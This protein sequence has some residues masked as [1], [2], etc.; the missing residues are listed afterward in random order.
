MI[1]IW[2]ILCQLVPFAQVVLLTA[3]EYLRDEEQ[4]KEKG[5]EEKETSAVEDQATETQEAGQVPQEE[6]VQ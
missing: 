6:K 5:K 1:D 2:L 4:E 3:M